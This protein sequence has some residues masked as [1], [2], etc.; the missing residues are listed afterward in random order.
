LLY[1]APAGM[2]ALL[3][4]PARFTLAEGVAGEDGYDELV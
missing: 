2:L 1:A 3:L 4:N